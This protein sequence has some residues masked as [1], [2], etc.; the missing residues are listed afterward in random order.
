MSRF[1]MAIWSYF[2]Y[3]IECYNSNKSDEINYKGL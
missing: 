1:F 2:D 3:F